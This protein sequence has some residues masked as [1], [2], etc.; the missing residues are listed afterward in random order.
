MVKHSGQ[1]V[2]PRQTMPFANNG[3]TDMFWPAVKFDLGLVSDAC[4]HQA[5]EGERGR[6][7]GGERER[8]RKREKESEREGMD[9]YH[10][11]RERMDGG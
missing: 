11:A 4:F 6:G 5:R 10:Q 8:E 3:V 9:C 7:R 2:P 1:S